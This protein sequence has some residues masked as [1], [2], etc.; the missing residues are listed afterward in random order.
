MLK[1]YTIRA[2]SWFSARLIGP[3]PAF[4]CSFLS[5]V[6]L[7]DLRCGEGSKM[8]R[9]D[10]GGWDKEKQAWGGRRR[11]ELMTDVQLAARL[12]RG[13]DENLEN[14]SLERDKNAK[15]GPGSKRSICLCSDLLFQNHLLVLQWKC[16]V[17]VPICNLHFETLH[18]VCN[19]S[20]MSFVII[21]L[22]QRN[23]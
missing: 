23:L 10:G 6:K 5:L 3:S 11:C 1:R 4:L 22:Q 16:S 20:E 7:I 9:P 21:N 8:G 13:E 12:L 18:R 14:R 15:R 19:L 2:A 17:L